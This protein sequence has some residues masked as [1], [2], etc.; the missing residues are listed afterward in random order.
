[1]RVASGKVV[2]KFVDCARSRRTRCAHRCPG[3]RTGRPGGLRRLG[4]PGGSAAR[5]EDRPTGTIFPFCQRSKRP[6]SRTRLAGGFIGTHTQLSPQTAKR[7]A[8]TRDAYQCPGGLAVLST[9]CGEILLVEGGRE[10]SGRGSAGWLICWRLWPTRLAFLYTP[11]SDAHPLIWRRHLQPDLLFLTAVLLRRRRG[12]YDDDDDTLCTPA[13]ALPTRP[14]EAPA[15]AISRRRFTA[16]DSSRT[17]AHSING[18]CVFS[19]QRR[20]RT[21][22]SRRRYIKHGGCPG[23]TSAGRRPR[24]YEPMRCA[25]PTSPSPRAGLPSS[26]VKTSTP[27]HDLRAWP[28]CV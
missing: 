7:K 11:S 14:I 21:G 12:S 17:L 20:P 6:A 15:T 27:P 8:K 9:S 4:S 24:T 19:T 28:P 1:M 18:P 16:A 22:C 5:Y 13:T 25:A 10:T 26:F 2:S 3:R 23:H